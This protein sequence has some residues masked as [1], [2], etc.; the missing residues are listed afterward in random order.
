[1]AP[2]HPL[3]R[4]TTSTAAYEQRGVL[5]I[6]RHA[7]KR[8]ADGERWRGS[9][10]CRERRGIGGLPGGRQT[11]LG[12][13]HGQ[14]TGKFPDPVE[15]GRGWRARTSSVTVWHGLVSRRIGRR[16]KS[17][18]SGAAGLRFTHVRPTCA[19]CPSVEYRRGADCSPARRAPAAP[20]L[21]MRRSRADPF[22]GRRRRRRIGDAANEQGSRVCGH[23]LCMPSKVEN[24]EHR[25]R[26]LMPAAE[27]PHRALRDQRRVCRPTCFLPVHFRYRSISL[28]PRRVSGPKEIAQVQ[29][30]TSPP[31]SAARARAGA[32]GRRPARRAKASRSR[33]RRAGSRAR[34]RGTPGRRP[35][36][37]AAAAPG[38]SAPRN[39]RQRLGLAGEPDQRVLPDRDRFFAFIPGLPAPVREAR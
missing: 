13:F 4:Q 36:R 30:G 26:H 1:M 33:R 8:L 29:F 37:A 11:R 3:A 18:M 2:S 6:C 38:R 21:H 15:A 12:V 20:D 17:N 31:G 32:S 22:G 39:A 23:G 25:F 7:C 35:G 27:W 16:S 9:S 10:G 24:R 5:R 34:S 28:H 19:T 14:P